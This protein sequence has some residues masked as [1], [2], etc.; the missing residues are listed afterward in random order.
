MFDQVFANLAVGFSAQFGGPYF[1]AV[2]TWP[3]T[4]VKDAGGSITVPASPITKPCKAQVC[5][6]SDEMRADA[7]FRERDMQVNVLAVTLDGRLDA[8]ATI[9][10]SAG[11][12][13]GTWALQSVTGDSAGIGWVCR[14]R[15]A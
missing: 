10:V 7:G 14:G 4:P 1:D 12:H 15:M 2:A 11:P 13:A 6:P 9:T 8:D 5:Q 3:G